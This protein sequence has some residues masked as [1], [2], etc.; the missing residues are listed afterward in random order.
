M[1]FKDDHRLMRRLKTVF[2]RLDDHYKVRTRQVVFNH[3]KARLGRV[4]KRAVKA[5]EIAVCSLAEMLTEFV[6]GKDVRE[7]RNDEAVRGSEAITATPD[8]VPV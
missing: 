2:A 7:V 8:G 4:K 1:N 5:L 3:E 6:E